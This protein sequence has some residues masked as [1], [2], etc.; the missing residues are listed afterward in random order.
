[1]NMT[2][3]VESISERGTILQYM[4]NVYHKYP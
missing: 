2:K 1:M 4:E 3:H